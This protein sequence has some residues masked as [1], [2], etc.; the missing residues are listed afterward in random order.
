MS[1]FL[2]ASYKIIVVCRNSNKVTMISNIYALGFL[3]DIGTKFP[4]L[5]TMTN[6]RQKTHGAYKVG[7]PLSTE[8]LH[9]HESE[10]ELLTTCLRRSRFLPF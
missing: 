1:L 3:H 2:N 8:F 7:S 4:P 6:L 5:L 9:M 10:I